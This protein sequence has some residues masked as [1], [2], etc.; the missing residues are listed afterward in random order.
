MKAR[1]AGESRRALIEQLKASIRQGEEYLA[2][3]RRMLAE[4][5]AE[6]YAESDF[7]IVPK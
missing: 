7:T 3:L 5:E 6:E 1:E 2:L 4:R